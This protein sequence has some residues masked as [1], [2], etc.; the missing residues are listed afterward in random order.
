MVKT[1]KDLNLFLFS[2]SVSL[3]FTVFLSV[4]L[5]HTHTHTHTH[6]KMYATCSYKVMRT[7]HSS[8]F[9]FCHRYVMGSTSKLHNGCQKGKTRYKRLS[10]ELSQPTTCFTYSEIYKS[11]MHNSKDV[12]YNQHPN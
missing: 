10:A 12:P 7:L 6:T 4:S 3:G 11:Y 5:S 8:I 1:H 9:L 2:L